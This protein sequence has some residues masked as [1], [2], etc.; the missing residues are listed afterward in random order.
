MLCRATAGLR[1]NCQGRLP[2]RSFGL[3]AMTKMT[4]TSLPNHICTL[5]TRDFR[6]CLALVSSWTIR[7]CLLSWSITR[8]R[9]NG[10]AIPRET[11]RLT[12][13]TASPTHSDAAR[14]T[15]TRRTDPHPAAPA[16][17]TRRPHSRP[18]AYPP[19]QHLCQPV[20]ADGSGYRTDTSHTRTCACERSDQV[21]HDAYDE[22]RSMERCQASPAAL[23][24]PRFELAGV[25]AGSAQ[26][27][28]AD[29]YRSTQ[30]LASESLRVM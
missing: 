12:T 29:S 16:P 14:G 23:A 15:G 3:A 5:T 24:L 6:P 28:F 26:G 8:L 22:D 25:G 13:S 30:S 18:S 4:D 9:Q 1:P 7:P 19:A 27:K 21:A 20:P 2:E 17:R 10:R 11:H